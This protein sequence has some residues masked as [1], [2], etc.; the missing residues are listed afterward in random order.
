MFLI[1]WFYIVNQPQWSMGFTFSLIVVLCGC[2]L[3]FVYKYAITRCSAL[4]ILLLLCICNKSIWWTIC[5]C[6]PHH[7][8]QVQGNKFARNE[9]IKKKKKKNPLTIVLIDSAI[10]SQILPTHLVMRMR[11]CLAVHNGVVHVII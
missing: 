6:F 2:C 8:S 5:V 10:S 9:K 7:Q 4:Q 11:R 3:S 1:F